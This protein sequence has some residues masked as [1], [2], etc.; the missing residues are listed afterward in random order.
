[1]DT[2]Q[3]A[4]FRQYVVPTKPAVCHTN[5]FHFRFDWKDPLPSP[6][7]YVEN[8]TI[9]TIFRESLNQSE[10]HGMGFVLQLSMVFC[11]AF[12]RP[13]WPAARECHGAPVIL[14]LLCFLNEFWGNMFTWIWAVLRDE[15]I[16]MDDNFSG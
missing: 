2:Q 12:G 8:L 14:D 7:T 4:T 9:S 15:Q 3:G 16:A 1:M 6:C 5:Q 13:I 11:R 10:V